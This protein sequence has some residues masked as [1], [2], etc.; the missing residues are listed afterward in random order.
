MNGFDDRLKGFEAEFKRDEDLA[1]RI[2]ARG[3]KL[4]GLWAAGRLGLPAGEAAETYAQTVIAADFEAP[5]DDDVIEKVRADFVAKSIGIAVAELRTELGRATLE[6]R[7][8][9]AQR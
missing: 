5:G 6:A 2:T 1:F 9:L 8:Q 4:L 3:N 7:K